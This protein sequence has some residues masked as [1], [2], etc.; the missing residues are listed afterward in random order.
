M[1]LRTAHD[2]L[3]RMALVPRLLEARGLDVTPGI[4]GRRAAGFTEQE[5][6]LLGADRRS[7]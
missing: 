2:P 4:R 7:R 6:A 1:A 3:V 5:I